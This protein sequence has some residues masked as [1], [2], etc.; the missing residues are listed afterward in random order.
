MNGSC[1]FFWTPVAD[2]ANKINNNKKEK[3][4]QWNSCLKAK[5]L[6]ELFLRQM[7]RNINQVSV[8]TYNF[9]DKENNLF[10]QSGGCV[11]GIHNKVEVVWSFSQSIMR[12]YWD[13]IVAI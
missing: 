4:T 6:G 2:T 11:D 8:F 9:M 5:I 10:F 1:F 13:G 7:Q 3:K 12:V